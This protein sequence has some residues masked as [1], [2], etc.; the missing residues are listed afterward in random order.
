M[1]VS[2]FALMMRSLVVLPLLLSAAALQAEVDA[3]ALY[4]HIAPHLAEDRDQL[5]LACEAGDQRA[6]Q[7]HA[8]VD[9]LLDA[10]SDADAAC[11]AGDDSSCRDLKFGVGVLLVGSH[12]SA[13]GDAEAC[14]RI[15]HVQSL[16][17]ACSEGS[18]DAC[19]QIEFALFG[20]EPEEDSERHD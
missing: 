9:H 12:C 13:T 1:E 16:T 20:T 11:Q 7:A 19:E 6:C 17:P 8:N 15:E 14:Q 3:R 4:Q 5:H 2:M 18:I 10:F